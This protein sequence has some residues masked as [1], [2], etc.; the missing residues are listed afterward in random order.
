MR[1]TLSV[2]LVAALLMLTACP[3]VQTPIQK[4]QIAIQAISVGLPIIG[5]LTGVPAD[6]ITDVLRYLGEAN[7]A[8]SQSAT[9]LQGPGTDAQKAAQITAAFAS[10]AKPEVPVK[11]QAIVDVVATVA[12]DVAAFLANYPA[13]ELKATAP[14]TTQLSAQDLT[15][16]RHAREKAAA[17][18]AAIEKLKA[19]Q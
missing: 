13:G 8:L 15:A 11:Y 3:A 12:T 7:D 6:V 10:I 14:K 17:N 16:L 2:L 19:K 18:T 9:I 5:G 4:L 1:T